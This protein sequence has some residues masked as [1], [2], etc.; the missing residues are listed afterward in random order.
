MGL[1]LPQTGS[2]IKFRVSSAPRIAGPIRERNF[3]SGRGSGL[4]AAVGRANGWKEKD[5]GLETA[6]TFVNE[7]QLRR[8]RFLNQNRSHYLGRL[9][10]GQPLVESL[11]PEAELIVIDAKQME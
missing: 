11:M 5:F 8:R 7:V 1:Q 10:S 3:W 2:A 6:A 4:Q 9:D